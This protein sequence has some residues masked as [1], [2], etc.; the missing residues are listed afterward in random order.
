MALSV[1]PGSGASVAS[2]VVSGEHIQRLKVTHGDNN[3]ATLTSALN[4]LPVREPP[5]S[6]AFAQGGVTATTASATLVAAR[7]GRRYVEVA[8]GGANGVWVRFGATAAV[9]GQGSYVPS[10]STAAWPFDGEVRIIVET[11]GASGPVGYTEW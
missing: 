1:T 5:L 9:A 8:N 4:P 7:S 6:S 10:K 2:D 11:G 3:I